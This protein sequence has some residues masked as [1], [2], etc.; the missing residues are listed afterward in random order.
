[1]GDIDRQEKEREADRDWGR[2]WAYQDGFRSSALSDLGGMELSFM[3]QG[4]FQK[5]EV[6]ALYQELSL[7]YVKF[8]GSV[9][10]TCKDSSRQ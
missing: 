4:I 7:V 1:M 2:G 6:W 9:G 5:K 8:E 10:H 3:R